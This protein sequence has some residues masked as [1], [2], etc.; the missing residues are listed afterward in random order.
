MTTLFN[1]HV[2]IEIGQ[3]GQ[4]GRR[5]DKLFM[6]F[7]FSKSNGSNANTGKVSIYNLNSRSR[8]LIAEEG[9]VYIFRAGYNGI[10]EDPLVEILSSGNM[11]SI[12]TEKRGIDTVTMLTLSEDGKKLREKTIDK[13]FAEGINQEVIVGELTKV[14]DIAKG[15]IKGITNKVFNSG[16]SVSG[17]VKDRL[18]EIA[19][20]DNLEW[21]VQNGEFQML[22]PGESTD[23]TAVVLTSQTGLLSAKKVK[24][25]EEDQI[26][27]KALLN[28]QVKVGRK[29]YI[30][31]KKIDGYFV[32]KN[33]KYY[34]DN[35]SGPFLIEGDAV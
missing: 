11:E 28:P 18:D 30:K 10:A 15:T 27:F 16:V 23:E 5:F 6:S 26:K 8:E 9:A 3:E 24:F 32:V 19:K 1:R 7:E 17:K 33:V 31:D 34:G 25:N 14:L 13:S 4:E 20:N 35:R 2:S 21:S 12:S 29:V 22:P